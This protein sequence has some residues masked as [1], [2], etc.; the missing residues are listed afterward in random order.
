M[1]MHMGR[2]HERILRVVFGSP[3][4]RCSAVGGPTPSGAWP[5]ILASITVAC[6]SEPVT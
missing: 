6:E 2:L 5:C 3:I 1:V 4:L